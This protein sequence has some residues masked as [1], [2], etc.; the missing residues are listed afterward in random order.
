MKKLF[1]LLIFFTLAVAVYGQSASKCNCG[2]FVDFNYS[3]YISI[4]DKPYGVQI[5]QSKNNIKDEDFLIMNI[6]NDSLDF[7][8]ANI[9]FAIKESS[10][11]KGWVKKSKAIGTYA[12]NYSQGD[13]LFLYSKADTNSKISTFIPE[14][15][16]NVYKIEKCYNDWVYV[17]TKYKGKTKKGWLQ[18]D[19]QCANPYTTCN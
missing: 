16:N 12:R 9:G 13:T 3:G 2:A 18:P 1:A 4:Y 14:W 10:K 15:I 5:G 17:I 8:Y 6:E 11:I 19:R 7:L